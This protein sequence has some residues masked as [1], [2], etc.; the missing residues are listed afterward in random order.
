M[1][2]T[3]RNVILATFNGERFVVTYDDG[4]EKDAAR[5]LGRWAENPAL[6]FSWLQANAML[7]TMKGAYREN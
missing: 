7:K 2:N 3:K 6:N 5:V 1:N 4:Y